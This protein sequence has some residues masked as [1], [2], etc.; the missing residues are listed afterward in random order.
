MISDRLNPSNPQFPRNA[1]SLGDARSQ[2]IYPLTIWV[3]LFDFRDL[4]LI[5]GADEI[6]NWNEV[7]RIKIFGGVA[8]YR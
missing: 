6:R 1:A 5:H 3:V 7:D 2:S 4:F 8:A